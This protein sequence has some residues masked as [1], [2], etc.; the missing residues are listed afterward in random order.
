[1]NPEMENW[2]LMGFDSS[3][4]GDKCLL[5]SPRQEGSKLTENQLLVAL[6]TWMN[7]P[8]KLLFIYY[9]FLLFYLG[10]IWQ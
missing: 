8:T 7:V 3:V 10:F 6:N 1:M 9:N 5:N 2:A 4:A